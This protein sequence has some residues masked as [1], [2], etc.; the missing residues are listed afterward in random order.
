[1]VKG[2][3]ADLVGTGVGACAVSPGSTR[4]EMLAATA[5]LY[6]TSDVDAFA[7][8]QLLG[9]VLEADEVASAI[10]YCCSRDS[11]V[12]GSVV[13]ADGGFLP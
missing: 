4:T 11:V 10:E 5:R 3:A 12:N 7:A 6:G 2:L 8:N 1:M 13:Y 9:R